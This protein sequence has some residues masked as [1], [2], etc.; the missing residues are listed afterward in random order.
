MADV[1]AADIPKGEALAFGKKE[2]AAP[3][4]MSREQTARQNKANE[5][6]KLQN[7][8]KTP[9]QIMRTN[10]GREEFGDNQ[11]ESLSALMSGGEATIDENG[12]AKMPDHPR[13]ESQKNFDRA[14]AAIDKTSK[15]IEYTQILRDAARDGKNPKDVYSAPPYNMRDADWTKNKKAALDLLLK[16]GG[17]EAKFGD[18][19]AG[20]SEDEKREYID[21][22]L[23]TDSDLNRNIVT[24][25]EDIRARAERD[26]KPIQ[27]T[28]DRQRLTEKQTKIAEDYKNAFD[29]MFKLSGID[30]SKQAEIE[31]NLRPLIEIGATGN[32]IQGQLYTEALRVAGISNVQDIEAYRKAN[33]T[34]AQ[35]VGAK[36]ALEEE[37]EDLKRE[38]TT[39]ADKNEKGRINGEIS[40]RLQMI[41]AIPTNLSRQ[42]ATINGI[43]TRTGNDDAELDAKNATLASIRN[44]IYGEPGPNNTVLGG[45]AEY[46]GKV[47]TLQADKSLITSQIKDADSTQEAMR[48]R[49]DRL[50][51]E[52]QLITELEGVLSS[53]VED[54]LVDRHQ[55]LV[56][57]EG[58][59]LDKAIE[60]AG[61]SGDKWKEYALKKLKLTTKTRWIDMRKPKTKVNR[62]AIQQDGRK[63]AQDGE[64]G[65][66]Q[67]FAESV[68]FNLTESAEK[69]I[70]QR[71]LGYT[72]IITPEKQ[73][74]I[75]RRY[76]DRRDRFNALYEEEGDAF[77]TKFMKD[78][79]TARTLKNK[80]G[81][82]AD[83]LSNNE[84][85]MLSENFDEL[86]T[87]GLEA[88]KEGKA[89]MEK[90][91]EAGINVAPD[92]KMK[93]WLWML[94]GVA[95]VAGV[96]AAA[97]LSKKISG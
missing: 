79:F 51:A 70:I 69:A 60:A 8:G 10:M 49:S 88:S 22:V 57:L 12:K 62:D 41:R 82:S 37:V 54:V 76:I 63:F 32:T 31:A 86:I 65:A 13:S 20:L 21:A 33:D 87:K 26:L 94:L 25:M 30:P 28:G 2:T 38:L 73:G 42:E 52:A 45:V 96:G 5:F 40:R 27:K 35:L 11:R 43:K 18:E 78:L 16:D 68:N 24:K 83:I 59:R 91:R 80:L 19:L 66:K 92:K 90:L 48:E 97:A 85:K 81:F 67:V 47:S 58:V 34:R 15:V 44:S 4:G 17:I 14:K 9:E 89:A 50:S 29:A 74:E 95:G 1:K 64:D 77:K 61:K 72:G 55:E 7:E 56:R 46:A 6:L 84:W 53:S 36:P 75:D 3:T 93:W 39:T 23:A 71:E